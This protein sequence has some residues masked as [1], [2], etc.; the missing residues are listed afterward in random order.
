MKS[1]KEKNKTSLLKTERFT[2]KGRA[3]RQQQAEDLSELTQM[4][5][6]FTFQPV[7]VG[8]P[9]LA[10]G[11]RYRVQGPITSGGLLSE[12]GAKCDSEIPSQTFRVILKIAN[13]FQKLKCKQDRYSIF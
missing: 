13:Q 8:K 3:I 12:P 6:R 5:E 10:C 9:H 1:T 7:G 4:W 11:P 2:A